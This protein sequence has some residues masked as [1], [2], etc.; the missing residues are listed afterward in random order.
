MDFYFSQVKRI[1]AYP[2]QGAEEKQRIRTYEL[3]V[4]W[5]KYI[6]LELECDDT[7]RRD[8]RYN[9]VCVVY[10]MLHT[11]LAAHGGG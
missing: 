1:G 5:Y 3:G 6:Q 8:R 10:T 11:W 7:N 2:N 4:P 9:K